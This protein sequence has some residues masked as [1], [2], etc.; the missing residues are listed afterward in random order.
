MSNYMHPTPLFGSVYL[1]KNS[2]K[3]VLCKVVKL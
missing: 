2:I 1:A 3:A